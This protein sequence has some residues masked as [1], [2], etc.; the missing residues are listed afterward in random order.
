[1]PS[2]VVFLLKLELKPL[3]NS[4]KYVFLGPKETLPVI[5]SFL[6]YYDQEEELIHILS[7]YK[8]DIGW[9]VADLK[10]ISLIICIHRIHLED[11]AKPVRQNVD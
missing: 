1:M 11:N 7:D 6:L 5:I 4:L 2:S 10:G 9:S 8:G 3:P